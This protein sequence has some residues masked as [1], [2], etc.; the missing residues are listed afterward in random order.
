MLLVL[1]PHL[2]ELVISR[3]SATTTRAIRGR[4]NGRWP[5][6]SKA[7]GHPKSEFTKILFQ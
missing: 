1:E 6:A 5:K 7:G 4:Q 3:L 2:V